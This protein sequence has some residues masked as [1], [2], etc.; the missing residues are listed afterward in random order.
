MYINK[1]F[2]FIKKYTKFN[3]IIN[4]LY[5]VKHERLVKW[6][7]GH[8]PKIMESFI[9]PVIQSKIW[10]LTLNLAHDK[11][12]TCISGNLFFNIRLYKYIFNYEFM[13]QIKFDID[14]YNHSKLLFIK[15]R[16]KHVANGG[17]LVTHRKVS[18]PELTA[19]VF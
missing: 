1:L 2:M 4:I 12:W 9:N 16:P 14:T 3:L 11:K 5:W 13:I 19:S 10:Y 6:E 15:L 17:G 18:G 8:L 7:W